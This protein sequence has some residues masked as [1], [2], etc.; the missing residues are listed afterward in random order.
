[1]C[2]QGGECKICGEKTHLVK[3]C[4]QNRNKKEQHAGTTEF[5]D[6]FD[7]KTSEP[8]KPKKRKIKKVQF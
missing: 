2:F 7:E 1:M 6:Y 8:P 3:D 4:P 5:D